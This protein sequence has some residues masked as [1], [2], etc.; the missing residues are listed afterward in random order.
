MVKIIQAT[1]QEQLE[2]ARLLFRRYEEWLGLDLCFQGF[3]VELANLPGKYE[4]PAGRLL[5]AYLDERLAGCIALRKLE[6]GICEMKRLYVRDEFQGQ[7]IG[8][9]LIER[10][11]GDARDIG[12]S[13]MRLDTYPAKMSK[14]VSIY[15]SRGFIEIPPYY[16][17]PHDGV[18][19]MEF[20]L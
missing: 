5:L 3:E 16:T 4:P 8:V 19:F 6:D 1:T 9:Q 7:R 18:L 10:L 2:A 12:Y 20:T 14:A 13:K 15:E 17:N 11:I